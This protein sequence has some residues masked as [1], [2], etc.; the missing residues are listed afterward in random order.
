MF[1]KILLA[2]TLASSL[3]SVGVPAFAQDFGYRHAPPAPRHE[4]MPAPR[5]GYVWSPGHWERRGHQ[6]AWVNGAWMRERRGEHFVPAQ[7][8]KRDGRYVFMQSH[9]RRDGDRDSDGVPNRFDR[10]P[11]DRGRH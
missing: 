6:Y 9:W 10:R 8:T 2:V 5:H 1:R 7:W 3:G 4:V 11:D